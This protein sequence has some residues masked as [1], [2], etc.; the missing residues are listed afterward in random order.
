MKVVIMV[1]AII[2]NIQDVLC[3]EHV[4]GFITGP[5]Y[6]YSY[7]RA[8]DCLWQITASPGTQVILILEDFHI[9]EL[10]YYDSLNIR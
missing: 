4:T 7:P 5:D 9:D 8:L 3:K 10:C 2:E 1:V 6:P